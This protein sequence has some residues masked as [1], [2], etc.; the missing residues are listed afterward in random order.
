M[1][2]IPYFFHVHSKK[3]QRGEHI[4]AS[5]E[6]GWRSILRWLTKVSIPAKD[7][8]HAILQWGKIVQPSL[9]L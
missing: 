6:Q 1:V 4:D 9:H 8:V 7:T 3:T 2:E 5:C